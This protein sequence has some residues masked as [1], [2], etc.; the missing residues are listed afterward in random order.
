MTKKIA[1]SQLL[2][3]FKALM[4][5][6]EDQI[7]LHSIVIQPEKPI[8]F[9]AYS[10]TISQ[11]EDII[12]TA[13]QVAELARTFIHEDNMSEK[14]LNSGI[15]HEIY[16]DGNNFFHITLQRNMSKLTIIASIQRDINQLSSKVI[17]SAIEPLRVS[18]IDKTDSIDDKNITTLP[19]R[20]IIAIVGSNIHYNNIFGQHLLNQ[21]V[22]QG[23][24]FSTLEETIYGKFHETNILYRHTLYKDILNPKDFLTNTTIINQCDALYISP[25]N[26]ILP[27]IDQ[28]IELSKGMP[29]IVI[30]TNK[31]EQ[32][33]T[34][35]YPTLNRV[36]V[37]N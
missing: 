15:G 23:K 35:T 4:K 1:N 18:E 30:E 11:S 34:K 22:Q 27:Y 12:L 9:V 5:Y 28:L 3:T 37:L 21:M 7:T 17:K 10:N 20:G 26:I 29:I 24:I 14:L 33:L 31:R 6:L 25:G 13:E 16:Q 32:T 2:N 19:E 36:I 8:S